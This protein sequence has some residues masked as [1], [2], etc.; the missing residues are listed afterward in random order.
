T[1]KVLKMR[2]TFMRICS[3]VWLEKPHIGQGGGD[4]AEPFRI[5]GLWTEVKGENCG[6]PVFHAGDWEYDPR[7]L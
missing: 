7:P 6:W 4:H 3:G 2:S 1:P 5:G